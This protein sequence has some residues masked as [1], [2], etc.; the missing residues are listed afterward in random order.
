MARIDHNYNPDAPEPN[1][2]AGRPPHLSE[3]KPTHPAHP[4]H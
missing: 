3:T 1:S 4:P 2:I